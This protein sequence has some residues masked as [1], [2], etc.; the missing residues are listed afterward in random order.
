MTFF[1]L[2]LAGFPPTAGFLGKILILSTNV[3]TGFPWLAGL[4][5]AGTAISLYAYFKVIRLMYDRHAVPQAL[6]AAKAPFAYVS[7]GVCVVLVIVMTFYPYTP[8]NVLPLAQ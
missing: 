6:G 5:I 2:A 8:S 4:L 1:L 3:N 7:V